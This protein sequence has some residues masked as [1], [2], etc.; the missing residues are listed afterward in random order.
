MR[1]L[2]TGLCNNLGGVE[3]FF[4]GYFREI[5]KLKL[6]VNFDVLGFHGVVY[7]EEIIK[8]GGKVFAINDF[9]NAEIEDFMKQYAINYDVVWCHA[10]DLST[11]AIMKYAN[12]YGIKKIILHSHCSSMMGQGFN[13]YKKMVLHLINKRRIDKYVTDYWACSD[14][15]AKWI[16]PPQIVRDKVVY[17]PN[18]IN[19]LKYK[20]DDS[21]RKKIRTEFKCENDYVI[22]F[23]GRL[24]PEKN[25]IFAIDVCKEIIKS[26]KCKLLIIGQGPL[27]KEIEQYI[28]D[29][30]LGQTVYMLGLRQDV[31]NIMQAL[32][33]VIIPS[34]FEG[35]PMVAIEA[36]ASGLP[37]VASSE[38]ITQQICLLPSTRMLALSSGSKVW[39]KC[40]LETKEI[41]RDKGYNILT[42]KGFNLKTA[43]RD[44]YDKLCADR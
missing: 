31:N 12:K 6:D 4:F 8:A 22:G 3:S 13:K 17:I 42:Q 14:Y 18:A 36:Q 39:A 40:I 43:A 30:G 33:C 29:E 44:L 38:R 10:V 2:V 32:D 24:S 28:K 35:M 5:K 7:S 27:D 34:L 21:V 26:K 1:I 41:E 20:F 23:I 37:V 16:F 15:A 9:S 19:A 11:I 25:P